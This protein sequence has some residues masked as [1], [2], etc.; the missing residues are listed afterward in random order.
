ML[1]Y[2]LQK[3]CKNR[4]KKMRRNLDW[5]CA[6]LSTETW[7]TL[8]EPVLRMTTSE[9]GCNVYSGEMVKAIKKALNK[10]ICGK[11]TYFHR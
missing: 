4:E 10:N 2:M 9:E 7:V 8:S 6:I 3:M 5:F 11:E 1:E